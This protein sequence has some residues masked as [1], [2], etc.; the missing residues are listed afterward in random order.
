M[1]HSG[2]SV[3]GYLSMEAEVMGVVLEKV[4]MFVIG[5]EKF[6]DCVVMHCL[7]FTRTGL[8]GL[9]LWSPALHL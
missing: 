3:P 5:T 8:I 1:L 7:I 6:S 2:L 4:F 9:F